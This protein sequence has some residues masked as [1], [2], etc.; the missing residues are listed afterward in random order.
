MK[1]LRIPI[2]RGRIVSAARPVHPSGFTLVE[3]TIAA[4]LLAV[5]MATAIPTVAWI[6]R[7]RQA[8]ARQQAAV[9]GVGNLMERLAAIPWDE[10][11]PQRAGQFTLP[12]SL[13]RQLPDSSL[14][15]TVFTDPD[16]PQAKRLSIVLTWGESS[17]G[18]QSAPVRLTAWVYKPA[19][20]V[21]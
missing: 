4:V 2:R 17:A 10:I 19:G 13:A 6:V 18:T 9:L 16:E 20:G 1:P 7:Q 21:S 15:I 8:S 12:K 11:S 3:L 14:K 5:V